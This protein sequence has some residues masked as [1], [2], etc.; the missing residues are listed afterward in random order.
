M[1]AGTSKDRPSP[2]SYWAIRGRFAAGEYPGAWDSGEAATKIESLLSAGVDHFIDLTE[3]REL[4]PY[5]GILEE[6]ASRLGLR[7]GHERH[8]IVDGRVPDSPE[9]M[10]DIL[11]AIDLALSEGKTVY[12]HCWGGVGRTG[13]AVGCWLVRHGST[14]EQALHQIGE[15]WQGVEKAWRIPRSPE[16][17]QQ[18]EY[19]RN[20][21]E[22]S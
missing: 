9:E 22:S 18:V 13:T 1:R 10:A 17:P 21:T 4:E 3:A 7:A 2:N 14:G 5:A 20:W 16:T 8:P 6:V 15:W 12:L 19:V 11:D